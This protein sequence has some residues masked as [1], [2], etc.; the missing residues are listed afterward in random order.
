MKNM[1][2]Y[3]TALLFVF[4]S[5]IVFAQDN[6]DS[7]RPVQKVKV[8]GPKYDPLRLRITMNFP[9]NVKTVQQATQYILETINYKLVMSPTNPDETKEIISRKL[10]AQDNN[11]A[12][13]TIEDGLLTI[14][15][16]DVVLV[17]DRV[18]K[19]VTF[20]HPEKND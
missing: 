16:E 6:Q 12:L 10:M 1:F 7:D 20:E 9:P 13:R 18:N 17:V 4:I 11:G 14:S 19:L 8:S 5:S 3:A 15:G 2:K